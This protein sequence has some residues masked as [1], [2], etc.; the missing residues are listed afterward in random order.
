MYII[1]MQ[2]SCEYHS[3]IKKITLLLPVQLPPKK[4]FLCSIARQYVD[5][6]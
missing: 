6:M 3:E 5:I 4:K 2:K 1:L